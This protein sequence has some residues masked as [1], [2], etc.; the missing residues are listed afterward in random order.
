M[1]K[2]SLLVDTCM[3]GLTVQDFIID[4]TVR[5][6]L[7]RLC[8]LVDHTGILTQVIEPVIEVWAF[9]STSLINQESLI[10]SI[11]YHAVDVLYYFYQRKLQTLLWG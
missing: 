2:M 6:Y 10:R 5:N 11:A 8:R 7:I 4:W 1:Y 9:L 3:M